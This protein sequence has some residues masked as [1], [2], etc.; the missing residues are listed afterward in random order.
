MGSPPI[1]SSSVRFQ[2]ACAHVPKNLIKRLDD[3]PERNEERES[4]AKI[5]SMGEIMRFALHSE[6]LTMTLA[7]SRR[8][9]KESNYAKNAY[10]MDGHAN[11]R[12]LRLRLL[13]ARV[14][15][16]RNTMAGLTVEEIRTLVLRFEGL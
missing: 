3:D 2:D 13:N 12:F 16:R 8:K 15:L 10:V 11:D 14:Y 6:Q 7:I 4:V 5:I 1:P 9:F